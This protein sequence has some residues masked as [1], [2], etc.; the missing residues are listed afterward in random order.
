MCACPEVKLKL[1]ALKTSWV[2]DCPALD[3]DKQQMFLDSLGDDW[4]QLN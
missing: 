1:Y 4:T 3:L 2:M